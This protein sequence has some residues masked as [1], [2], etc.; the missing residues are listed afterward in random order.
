M[1]CRWD[2][3]INPARHSEEEEGGEGPQGGL[4]HAVVPTTCVSGPAGG[5]ALD[6]VLRMSN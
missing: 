1:A 2:S 6:P 3:P 4:A 5:A